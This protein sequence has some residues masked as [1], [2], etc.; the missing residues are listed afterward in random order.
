[1]ETG[2]APADHPPPK[3]RGRGSGIVA[4]RSGLRGAVVDAV[5]WISVVVGLGAIL[6]CAGAAG[7]EESP[8]LSSVFSQAAPPRHW[9]DALGW[10]L[11]GVVGVAAGW[12][13][14]AF[15]ARRQW[16]AVRRRC[17]ALTDLVTRLPDHYFR[18]AGDSTVTEWW[19][20]S[21]E[22]LF[23][24]PEAFLGRRLTEVLPGTIR[25]PLLDG[26][27]AVRGRSETVVLEYA[28]DVPSGRKEFE[29]RL[30]NDGADGAIA[31]IRDITERKRAQS[32]L[33][34]LEER[35][36]RSHKLEAVGT[37]AG[38][39]AHDF[40]NILGTIL[41]NVEMAV[42]DVPADHPVHGSLQAIRRATDRARMLV[43][44]LLAFSRMQ[45][46][47]RSVVRVGPMLERVV[48]S[49]R[50]GMPSGVR[51]TVW[52]DPACPE[53]LGDAD[54]L[55][56]V[57]VNIGT[58]AWQALPGGEGCLEIRAEAWVPAA[59]PGGP[60]GERFARISVRDDGHGMDAETLERVFDPFFTT[61]RPG[62]GSGLGLA[63]AHGTVRNHGGYVSVASEPGRGTTFYVDLPA[64]DTPRRSEG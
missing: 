25:G 9:S 31:V 45:Q 19:G 62:E 38:G 13:L 29:A 12:A 56:H 16:S 33:K 53:V 24:Q 18:I 17:A 28:L 39:V 20:G 47:E 11:L 21:M 63:V 14:G 44:Q 34:V 50:A 41:G 55:E 42:M 61:R 22:N 46:P 59:G 51:L 58:N 4:G 3:E 5:G 43:Q 30:R 49:L 48:A 52:C 64:A 7:L 35:L 15:W 1:M 57:L 10:V 60:S 26:L 36:R 8:L 37:L 27:A 23:A 54:Q 2:A 6:K 40:N 32:A